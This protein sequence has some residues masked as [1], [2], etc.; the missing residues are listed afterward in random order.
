LLDK[1]VEEFNLRRES[2]VATAVEQK[3]LQYAL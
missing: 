1:A 2:G 3:Y